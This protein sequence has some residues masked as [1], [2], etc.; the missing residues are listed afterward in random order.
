VSIPEAI[1][2]T[3]V[4]FNTL[5]QQVSTFDLSPDRTQI[6]LSGFANGMYYYKIISPAGEQSGKVI[7]G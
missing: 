1:T 6:D 7:K 2:G 5:G 3:I 4:F